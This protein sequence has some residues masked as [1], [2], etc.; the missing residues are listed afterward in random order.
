MTVIIARLIAEPGRFEN[1]P[2]LLQ[3]ALA[4]MAVVP[5][6]VTSPATSSLPIWNVPF[7]MPEGMPTLR[8]LLRMPPSMR[9]RHTSARFTGLCGSSSS[10]ITMTAAAAR[11]ARLAMAAP[12]TPIS[13]PKIRM[14]LPPMLMTF[15]TAD[16][17]SDTLLLPMLRNSAAPA[18]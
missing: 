7:S 18:L 16:A 11:L 10:R 13:S 15:I 3:M 9:T 1:A 14:A 5:N 17:N 6:D 8:M 2:T 4:V 12:A